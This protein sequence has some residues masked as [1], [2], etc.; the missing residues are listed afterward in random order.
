M[1]Y[2]NIMNLISKC[3][4]NIHFSNRVMILLCGLFVLFLFTAVFAAE[5]VGF[6]QEDAKEISLE[7]NN[8]RIGQIREEMQQVQDEINKYNTIIKERQKEARSLKREVLMQTDKI[9]KNELEIKETKLAIE[10]AEM[11]MEEIERRIKEGEEKVVKNRDVLKNLIKFLYVFEQDS[12]IEVLMTRDSISDFFNEIDAAESVKNEMFETIVD[13]RKEKKELI[14]KNEEL[15]NQQEEQGKLIQMRIDQNNSLDELK[16][17]KKELL[18]ITQGEEK[19]FQQ[20][21]AEN[22]SILPSLQ[23]QLYELQSLGQKIKFDD[24]FSAAK[25]IGNITGVR[26]AYLLG[27]LRVESG[28]G[29]NIGN[30]NYKVDMRSS[31]RPVFEEITKELG[32]NPNIMPVSRKPKNYSGW[33]GAMGPAQM[34]PTTWRAYQNEIS[35]I[36]GHYPPDPWDLTDAI[37]AM[38]V[39]VSK[40]AGVTEGN[41]NAEYE[42]AGLYFA[43]SNWRKFLFYPDR[44]MLYANLYKEEL[45]Q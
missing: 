14:L 4:N 3:K 21:L 10:G 45:G 18:E 2:L 16:D 33:G 42:A 44:V 22:K 7:E 25:Y 12:I 17:Q 13:L 6:A 15:E 5:K 11:E 26:P 40:V 23:A 30:G 19:Q 36:T 28:L 31:Q 9:N 32:Y 34:M 43:G 37:A 1:H 35:Q 27:I 39:K 41:Y 29:T 24:A 20:I 8:E 38:A